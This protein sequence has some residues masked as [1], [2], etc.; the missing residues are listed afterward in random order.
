[1]AFSFNEAIQFPT[2][3]THT[4]IRSQSNP[5]RKYQRHNSIQTRYQRHQCDNPIHSVRWQYRMSRSSVQSNSIFVTVL[6]SLLTF[7]ILERT[8]RTLYHRGLQYNGETQ[9][10]LSLRYSRQCFY[11]RF[12]VRIR[13][14]MGN[15]YEIRTQRHVLLIFFTW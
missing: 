12:T 6:F 15:Y 2:R 1:M 13:S 9:S 3:H 14:S 7:H 11:L 10:A 5:K 8:M 4:P